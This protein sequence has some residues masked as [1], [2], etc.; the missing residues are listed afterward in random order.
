MARIESWFNHDLKNVVK[1]RYIDGNVFSM[2]NDGN[3]I[4]VNVYDNGEPANLS[5]T[6]SANIIR[7]DGA[8]VPVTGTLAGNKVS[9]ILPQAAYYAAGMITIIIKLTSGSVIT[10]LFAAVVNVYQSS[11][12]SIVDPGTII[13]SIETLIA[14]IDAAIASIPADYSSLWTS[15]APTFSTSNTYKVGQYVTY[16]GG[17]YEFIADHTA[18]TWNADHVAQ[19][20]MAGGLA[21]IR[22]ALD[23]HNVSAMNMGFV[24]SADGAI[25]P[26]GG[27]YWYTNMIK[28]TP[29]DEYEYSLAGSSGVYIIAGYQNATDATPQTSACVAGTGSTASGIYTVPDGINYLRITITANS[30]TGTQRFRKV[31]SA[32]AKDLVATQNLF[33]LVK[34]HSGYIRKSDGTIQEGTYTYTDLIAVM[35]GE[36]Y[37][38]KSYGSSN[39]FIVGMY[40]AS[41]GNA[42]TS[43]SISGNDGGTI[44][45]KEVLIPAG[46]NYIRV[47]TANGG[48]SSA[49]LYKVTSENAILDKLAQG[50]GVVSDDGNAINEFPWYDGYVKAEDGSIVEGSGSYRYTSLIRVEPGEKYDF[51]L[52]GS[53][54]VL[55]VAMYDSENTLSKL[56]YSLIGKGTA[57]TGTLIIPAG[58]HY[59][60]LTSAVSTLSTSVFKRHVEIPAKSIKY[61]NLENR[62]LVD[63]IPIIPELWI[64]GDSTGY[65]NAYYSVENIPVE[66]GVFYYVWSDGR[67]NS[68]EYKSA[69]FITE[70]DSNGDVVSTNAYVERYFV[71]SATADHVTITFFAYNQFGD[72]VIDGITGFYYFS[73]YPLTENIGY[74]MNPVTIGHKTISNSEIFYERERKCTINFTFDDGVDEDHTLYQIFENHGA[75]CGFALIEWALNDRHLPWYRNYYNQGYSILCHSDNGDPMGDDTDYTP[76]QLKTRMWDSKNQLERCG[77]KISGWVTP[78]SYLK[79]DYLPTLRKYYDY[80]FT[81]YFGNYDGTGVPYDTIATPSTELKRVHVGGTTIENLKQA[82]DLAIQNRGFLSF[83]GH[84]YEITS[85]V[86]DVSKLIEL[87]EYILVRVNEEE[88]HLYAPDEA[89]IYYFRPRLSDMT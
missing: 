31:Y 55:V 76:E 4:G 33:N 25:Q 37:I 15:L 85:G 45:T 11:T 6:V 80:G 61:G 59:I 66:P 77:V 30:G 67:L 36:R 64:N 29:G 73:K 52:T 20:P 8:T 10:T 3:L 47:C 50:V 16:N 63:G 70:F 71:T 87:I 81:K 24:K 65:G 46:I 83:Y 51:D 74:Y 82:V 89:F 53:A 7:G 39:V 34:H 54:S 48:L 19:V 42:D 57:R 62:N 28:V 49:F 9:V 32:K 13:P 1:V 72:G 75:R 69:R 78:S 68:P 17:V 22:N 84:G 38:V 40:A 79:P 58:T 60:R 2:D 35:P 26:G 86:L 21:D 41:S 43:K 12:D 5:G 18:G 23:L 56:T 88:C 27:T 14:A 44:I